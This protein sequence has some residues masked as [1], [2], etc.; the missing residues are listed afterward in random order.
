MLRNPLF[1]I[2]FIIISLGG[3]I[4]SLNYFHVAFSILNID[5]E[6]TRES[7]LE[8]ARTLAEKHQLGPEN[9]KQAVLFDLDNEVQSYVELEAGG[10]DAFQKMI[11][12]D[13]YVPYTWIVRHFKEGETN[14]TNLVFTPGGRAYEFREKI[15]EDL[16]GRNV[17]NDEARKIAE[18]GASS[19]WNVTLSDFELVAQSQKEQPSGRNDYTFEYERIGLK[20][21]DAPY[22][23]KLVIA[24]DTLI[25]LDHYIKI[26]ES[27]T[28]RY[29]EMRSA[30]NTISSI[31]W[32]LI[33]TLYVFGGCVVGLYFLLKKRW[34]EWRQPLLWGAFVSLMATLAGINYFPLFW[35]EYN[36]AISSQTFVLQN[37][38]KFLSMFL[39][40]GI[41]FTII[42][43]AAESLTRKAFPE[44]LQLWKCWKPVPASSREIMGRS[45][46]GYL[47]VFIFLAYEIALH[48]VGKNFP[49]WWSPSGTI[50]NPNILATYFPWLS[51]VAISLQAGFMEECLFRAVP[52]AGAA[53]IGNRLGNRRLWI[54]GAFVIQAFIFGAGHANYPAQPSYARV[55]ELIIPSITF[56]LLYL[57]FGLL[58]AIIMHY[59]FDAV[60]FSLPLFVVKG[61]WFDKIILVMCILLPLLIIGYR[62]LKRRRWQEIPDDY[63]NKSWKPAPKL[64]K[65]ETKDVVELGTLAAKTKIGLIILGI[66]GLLLWIF[67]TNFTATI[68]PIQCNKND[69]RNEALQEFRNYEAKQID[70]WQ[71]LPSL[72]GQVN[73]QHRF[74]WQEGGP[75]VYKN[76]IGTYLSP[77]HW[78]I[79]FAKFQGEITARAEEYLVAISGQGSIIGVT[80]KL[81]ESAQGLDL[82]EEQARIIAIKHVIEKYKLDESILK[83]VSAISSKQPHRRD[84][85]FTFSDQVHYTLK[86]GQ[87]R[88]EVNIAGDE[89][90]SSHRYIHVPEQWRTLPLWTAN[91]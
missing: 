33:A 16:P 38:V 90:V 25:E 23:L 32:G 17:T 6:M 59:V 72:D 11:Q 45:V 34:I 88:I 62:G 87:A 55:I 77:P 75:E 65:L 20:A 13:K 18:E 91:H 66:A 56:G 12:D 42:F 2:L 76:L 3:L 53:L 74:I 60:L 40:N 5:I 61:L 69:A 52:I 71:V 29:K 67:V 35:M 80:H 85:T 82:S 49:G 24:G 43:M 86:Q 1:W 27:F 64:E 51:P 15:S 26:P 63:Y 44:H 41:I 54:I 8:A 28:R 30:N 21:G 73:V 31:A 39:F 81:P 9:F 36:T 89:I 4:F 47:L 22:R 10:K 7:A 50:A 83:D 68:P 48:L 70:D 84:W 79:R 14:E 78:L 57:Y 19:K 37:M 46:S 58:P